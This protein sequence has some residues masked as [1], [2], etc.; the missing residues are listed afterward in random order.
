MD[1]SLKKRKGP[2][3]SAT[4]F[5]IGIKKK[6]NDGNMWKIVKNKNG[7]KRWSKISNLKSKTIKS[8]RLLKLEKDPESVWGKNKKL[9]KFWRKLSTGTHVVLI[10]KDKPYNVVSLPRSKVA[11]QKKIEEYKN[12][13]NII[14]IITSA[15]SVD[16]YVSLYKKV[17]DKTPD[18]VIKNYK[19]ILT[20]YGN[21][22][23]WYL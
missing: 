10:Y 16:T 20:N 11:D 5:S 19:K 18:F 7:T 22:K 6:G 21:D 4:K 12:N 23:T 3:E 9:E 17:K 2:S 14:A 1:K 8:K 15:M 13:P